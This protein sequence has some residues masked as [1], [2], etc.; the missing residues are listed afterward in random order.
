MALKFRE[1]EYKDVEALVNMLFD[2]PLGTL[3]EDSSKPL[4]S[5]YLTAFEAILKDNNNELIIVENNDNIMGMLQLTF[6]PYLTH[7][8]SWRCLIEG[9]RVQSDCRGKGLGTQFFEWAIERA[10]QRGCNM[11]QLT[12]NKARV[13]ALRF[14]QNLGFEASHEG[15]KLML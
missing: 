5:A 12:S 15:F 8:G 4:N 2:D 13:D 10:K 14:Y 3:R 9:V 6:I 1:A 7:T 11:V